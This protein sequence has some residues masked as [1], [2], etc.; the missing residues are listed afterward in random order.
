MKAKADFITNS[1]SAS[2]VLKVETI[3][4]TSIE[5]FKNQFGKFIEWFKTNDDWHGFTE[6]IR[7]WNG[8]DIKE[9]EK[10]NTFIIEEWTSMYNGYEDIPDYMKYLTLDTFVSEYQNGY[11]FKI[12]GI[13]I[14]HD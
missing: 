14:Q 12:V 5:E 7:F 8:S 3:E 11:G 10:P 13:E 9:G 1:S 6:N 2:F 4:D